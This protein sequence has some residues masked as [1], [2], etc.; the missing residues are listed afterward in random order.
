[1]TQV[2]DERFGP[3]LR[4]RVTVILLGGIM[5]ILDGS[6]VMVAADTLAERFGASLATIGWASTGYLIALTVTVPVTAWAADRFGGRRL[7]LFGLVLFLAGSVAAG[8]AW[9]IGVLIAFRV[10]Q[11][12]AAGILDPLML[13]LLVRTAGPERSGRVVGL[14]GAVGSAGPVVGPIAGGLIVS[15]LDWHWMFFVNAPIVI[16]AFVL[17]VRILPADPPAPEQ[18]RTRLDVIGVALIGP[19]VA[20]LVLA[21]SQAAEAGRFGAPQVLAPL[22]IGVV[23][24]GVYIVHALRPRRTPPL[25]DPRVFA[26]RGFGA[27]VTVMTLSGIVTWGTLFAL[28]LFYQRVHGADAFDAGLM[29]APLGVGAVIAMPL[30]GRLSDRLGS[31]NLALGGTILGLV[32]SL[33]FTLAGTGSLLPVAAAFATG[34]GMGCAGAATMGAVFKLLPPELVAQGSSLLYMLNQLGASLGITVVALIVQSAAD[35]AGGFHNAAGT[36]AI[37][38]TVML[39]ATLFIPTRMTAPVPEGA[40]K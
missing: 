33:A 34:L 31:R 15:T 8:L 22:T 21:L 35:P 39:A 11:G 37:A 4:R 12:V 18:P 28:P 26:R 2:R 25:I 40:R 27:G 23:L 36:L 16:V 19:A 38:A 10:V 17:A 32:S 20:A 5:G 3:V 13:T 24:L 14:M 9:N 29:L 30:A 7:W 6:M 1:M